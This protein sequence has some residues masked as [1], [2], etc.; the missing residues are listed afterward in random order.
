MLVGD[1]EREREGTNAAARR[2]GE[3]RAMMEKRILS[4]GGGGGG[5][6]LVGLE[7]VVVDVNEDVDVD[8]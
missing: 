6:W 2:R 5:W 8:V 1:G 4:C 7:V 3:T